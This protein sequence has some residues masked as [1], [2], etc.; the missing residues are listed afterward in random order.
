MR[1]GGSKEGKRGRGGGG[2]WD[3]RERKRK[4]GREGGRE[5]S[6]FESKQTQPLFSFEE[7][8]LSTNLDFFF[9]CS[10]AKRES[11]T[12]V[13]KNSAS[14]A[15]STGTCAGVSTHPALIVWLKAAYTSSLRPHALV[16]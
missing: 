14:P 2:G 3:K 11:S 10:K 15:A 4:R 1:E 9:L 7:Q 13:Q 8:H 12:G 6:A 16:A 5:R